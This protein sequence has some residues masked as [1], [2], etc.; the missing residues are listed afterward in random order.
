MMNPPPRKTN[1][2]GNAFT[3]EELAQSP[4]KE[5]PWNQKGF[6]FGKGVRTEKKLSK[7]HNP[8][9]AHG[10]KYKQSFEKKTYHR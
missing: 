10:Y 4:M 5:I 9:P 6:D 2:D 8:S 1:L 7:E 3:E